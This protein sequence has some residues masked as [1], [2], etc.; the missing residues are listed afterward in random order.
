MN[1]FRVSVRQSVF[2]KDSKTEEE[3]AHPGVLELRELVFVAALARLG[4]DVAGGERRLGARSGLLGGGG[5]GPDQQD[6]GQERHDRPADQTDEPRPPHA[7]RSLGHRVPPL[8][9]SDRGDSNGE[10]IRWQ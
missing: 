5:P 4:A 10:A 6:E 8:W 2:S 9:P 3:T 7:W 1:G